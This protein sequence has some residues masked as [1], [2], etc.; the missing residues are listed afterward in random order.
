VD[1]PD[2]V[3]TP[4]SPHKWEGVEDVQRKPRGVEA[5]VQVMPGSREELPVC[6]SA[7]VLR[8]SDNNPNPGSDSKQYLEVSLYRTYPVRGESSPA[9]TPASNETWI[10]LLQLFLLGLLD[11]LWCLLL[12]IQ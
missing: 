5:Q 11:F 12:E 4:L 1:E 2:S 8:Y 3:K 9:S 6:D 10:F 7:K